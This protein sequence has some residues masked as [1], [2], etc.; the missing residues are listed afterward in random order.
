MIL[1]TDVAV[2]GGGVGGY[3]SAIRLGQLGKSVL[4][5]EKDKIG[6][7]CLNI[8]CIPSKALINASKLVKNARAAS[9]MGINAEVSVDFPK[10]QEWKQDVINK[11]TSGVS[12]LCKNNN[13]QVLH[14]EARFGSAN[15]LEIGGDNS[16]KV[17]EFKN[18]IVATGSSP[19]E[20]PELRFDG[21]RIISSTEALAL[22]QIP[23]KLLIV[24]GGVIGLEI[25]MAYANLFG[26]ELIV[27]EMLDQLLPGVDAD[28]VNLVS[29][30]LQRLN[31]GVYL[32]SKVKSGRVNADTVQ[33]SFETSKMAEQIAEVD[34]VL[35]S[36]GRRPNSGNL[37]LENIGVSINRKG[38]VEVDNQMR[39]SVENVFAVGDLVGEPLLAHKASRQGVVAAEVICGMKS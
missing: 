24:G 37:G 16:I 21:K 6:G 9:K 36:V 13:V 8:G 19:V 3:V 22:T 7:V 29:R 33:V 5:I 2:I 17:I 30:S 11:L 18:A 31:G 27:V 15:R 38:F 39:T 23:K 34:Y 4:L 10:L 20:L 25:G 35:V 14:G 26:T 32:K 28:L 12:S 1:R